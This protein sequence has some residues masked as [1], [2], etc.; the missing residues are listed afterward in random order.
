VLEKIINND[1]F[2]ALLNGA[3]LINKKL[4]LSIIRYFNNWHL[5]LLC[6]IVISKNWRGVYQ[7]GAF[8]CMVLDALE[9][10]WI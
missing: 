7:A 10:A 4:A 8:H 2:S 6:N 1:L 9:H 5:F 3:D